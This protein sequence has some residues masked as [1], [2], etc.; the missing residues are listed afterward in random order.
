MTESLARDREIKVQRADIDQHLSSLCS[1]LDISA[2]RQGALTQGPLE[3]QVLRHVDDQSG[4]S[5]FEI[6]PA[7]D[8][9]VE[10][11]TSNSSTTLVEGPLQPNAG[12]GAWC[13][14]RDRAPDWLKPSNV[15]W[16]H[17]VQLTSS[18]H[19]SFGLSKEQLEADEAQKVFRNL[20]RMRI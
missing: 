3:S 6:M 14:D 7:L 2:Q 16:G 18:I 11:T 5:N 17:A 19:Y 10:L 9:A 8:G 4:A 1:K 13:Q 20:S 15:R 12:S